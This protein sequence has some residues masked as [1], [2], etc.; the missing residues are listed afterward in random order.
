MDRH[1]EKTQSKNESDVNS[2]A[3]NEK[4]ADSK[5]IKRNGRNSQMVSGLHNLKVQ[6]C[7]RKRG[8]N[9]F[10]VLESTSC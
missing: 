4:V 9:R 7:M 10:Y 8:I 5:D 6:E 1:K 3:E 2:R